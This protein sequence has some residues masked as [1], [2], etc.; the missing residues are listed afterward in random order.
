MEKQYHNTSGEGLHA[1]P[2]AVLVG[3]ITSFKSDITLVYKEKTVN[4]KSILGVMSLGV[5]SGATVTI[6][7]N[8]EDEEQV[9]A[10]VDD[11]MQSE[12]LGK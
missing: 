12:G 3:A 8:G 10:K 11:I 5:A 7:A 6:A 2:T 4:L 9:M 1:R